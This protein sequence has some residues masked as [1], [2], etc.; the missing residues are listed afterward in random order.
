MADRKAVAHLLR[1]A[2]FGPRAEEVDAAEKAGYDA[3]LAAL[4]ALSGTD[5]GAA[6]TPVPRL[7]ADP[8]TALG[9]RATREQ[10]QQVNQERNKQVRSVVQW[11]L[12]RMAS[13]DHQL[14]EKLTF[15]WH[16][17]W[18]TSVQKVKSAQLMLAYQQTLFNTALG[19]RGVRE[20]G[21]A[22]V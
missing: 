6:K 15:F 16:G 18:A 1:R 22:R 20:E 17:H 11:W 2:T 21:E 19:D 3:T 10:R 8:A 9:K 5:A 7:G 12:D 14:H 4:F 13:A